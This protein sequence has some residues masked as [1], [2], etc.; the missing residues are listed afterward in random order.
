[1]GAPAALLAVLLL[2]ALLAP[3]LA[4]YDPVLHIDSVGLSHSPP[5]AAHP[6]GTDVYGR[7]VLSRVLHGARVSL[8]VGA[9]A[10]LVA[11]SLGT[12]VGV[13]AGYRGG[14]VDSI[15]MRLVDV[16]LALPRLLVLIAVLALWGAPSVWQLALLVGATGWLA[17][18][19]I[20]RAETRALR[21]RDYISAA[22]ALG[23]SPARVLVRHLGPGLAAPLLVATV[24]FTGQAVV[25][26][27]SLSYLGLGVRPPEASW[28]NVIQEGA[29]FIGTAW[30]VA[31]FP[32]LAV[33][34][35]VA[36]VNSAG[37]ALRAQLSGRGRW[38]PPVLDLASPDGVP[39]AGRPV[40]AIPVA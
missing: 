22:R 31:L 34:L 20:V 21:D 10:A 37:E 39:P 15:L 7:D 30:W 1:M 18:S 35:A 28:G 5:S 13:T 9:T 27:A 8:L 40:P 38:T 14:T 2:V 23:A 11:V 4:P 6:F 17:M 29:P 19:R 3:L 24:L 33:V 12:L 36:T 32:G 16:G 26:E 25:L